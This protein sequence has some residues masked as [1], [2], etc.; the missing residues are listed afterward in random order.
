M[1]GVKFCGGEGTG[2][3]GLPP[4][5][6]PA[7][8][9]G[10]TAVQ[11]TDNRLGP[12]RPAYARRLRDLGA[13]IFRLSVHGHTPELHDRLVGVPG[14]LEK[15][16]AAAANLRGLGV[17]LGINYVLNKINAPFFADT[18]AWFHKELGIEDVIVY[19][20]RYQGFGALPSNRELLKLSFTEAAPFV[21]EG[22]RRL[23]E[24]PAAKP[25]AL[26][27][28]PP[29]VLPELREHL[30]DWTRDP[31]GAGEGNSRRDRV[32]LPDG[33]GGLI[34]EITNSG[35]RPVP[36]CASCALSAECLGVEQNYLAEFGDGE[37]EP[38]PRREPAG[39]R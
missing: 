34:S 11:S 9:I 10:I 36:A 21:R 24:N 5:F 18:L 16:K 38:I 30:L 3:G 28:F 15:V 1:R 29:C 17:R 25:P 19:L 14:A 31:Q 35:K 39:V 2:R 32:A 4:V 37:F 22:F 6:G 33:S 7:R 13:G 23:L 27:H 12:G 20:L 26:I 8:Q